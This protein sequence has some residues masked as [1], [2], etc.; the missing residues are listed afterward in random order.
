MRFVALCRA[1]SLAA[2]AGSEGFYFVGAGLTPLVIQALPNPSYDG[3]LK[4]G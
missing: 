1:A 2:M 4:G 3:V